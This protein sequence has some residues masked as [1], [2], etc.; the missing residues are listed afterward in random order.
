MPMPGIFDESTQ[1]QVGGPGAHY[2]SDFPMA[3]GA[4]WTGGYQQM[5]RR[6]RRYPWEQP[7][8]QPQGGMFGFQSGPGGG[9]QSAPWLDGNH[10][11]GIQ[12]R[13]MPGGM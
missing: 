4:P 11:N 7:Y 8:E 13:G 5:Q 9:Q 1:M 10:L 6:K 3:M 12:R 2:G